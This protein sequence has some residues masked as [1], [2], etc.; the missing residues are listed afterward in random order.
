MLFLR[1]V[2]EFHSNKNI[3]RQ[4]HFSTVI[5]VLV[6]AIRCVRVTMIVVDARFLCRSYAEYISVCRLIQFSPRCEEMLSDGHVRRDR[7]DTFK[8]QHIPVQ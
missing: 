2:N 6:D 3:T 5:S 1:I 8:E 7:S 4:Y